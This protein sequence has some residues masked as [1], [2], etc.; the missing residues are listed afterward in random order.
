MNVTSV[1][2]SESREGSSKTVGVVPA[3]SAAALLLLG[4]SAIGVQ[5]RY[6][7]R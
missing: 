1:G 2:D 5:R 6:G 4:L 3:P 7:S